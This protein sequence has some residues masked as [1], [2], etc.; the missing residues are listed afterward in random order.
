MNRVAVVVL[1]WN[2]I[3]DTEECLSSLAKQSFRDFHIILVDN[4]SVEKNTE[5][6]LESFTDRYGELVTII[7]NPENQGFA[8]GVN[9]GIR[10][11]FKANYDYVALLNNDATA[12]ND[13]LEKLVESADKRGSGITTGLLLHSDG[14]TIDS[15][16][17]W[18]S[19]WGLPF[20]RNR[21]DPQDEAPD[22][23]KVFSGSGGASLYSVKMMKEIGLF[24]ET[25]FAYYE[26]TDVSFR[27]Q[28][29][30]W[31]VYYT[32]QAIA[33]HK[34][35]ATSSK[36]PGFAVRQTFKNLPIFYIK[37]MPTSLLLST[38]PRFTLAYVLMLGNAIK[39]GNTIPAL[40]GWLQQIPLFWFHALPARHKIQRD[41][42]V[43]DD[44]IRSLL[45]PDLPPDQ[46]GLRK[47]RSL[48]TG[49]K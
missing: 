31:E 3:E 45:W 41:K 29:Y 28:L 49:K 15:T 37:N 25:L 39:N 34:Q 43:S 48:F 20:P 11:V 1:N 16:G 22:S 5:A 44:Y 14:K 46:T 24:D 40:T 36:I 21:N 30:D 6:K 9:T 8:G 35:G 26:D 33:Y 27:A 13:W 10:W 23:Q 2:G 32:N 19:V 42:R 38:G 17:D 4:G 18:C 7:R 47:F 12:A